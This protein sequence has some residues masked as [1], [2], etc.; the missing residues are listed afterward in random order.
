MSGLTRYAWVVLAYNVAVIL[1]GAF[2]RATGSG[3]GCGSHWPLCNGEVVPRAASAQ[4]LIEFTHRATSGLAVLMVVALLVWVYRA[5]PTGHPARRA[6][7][8]SFIFILGE[9]GVGA[10]LVLLHLVGQNQSAGRA[11]VMALHLVNTFLLLGALTLTACWTAGQ[12]GPRPRQ[13]AGFRPLFRRATAGLLLVGASGAIAA[14]GDT[15]FPSSSLTAALGDDLSASAHFLL[16]LRVLHPVFGVGAGVLV[17][18][19]SYRIVHA[20]QPEA[21]ARATWT[22]VLTVLQLIAGIVNVGL[23]APVLMQM[24]HLLLADLVLIAFVTLWACV[25]NPSSP[26]SSAGH[27]ADDRDPPTVPSVGLVG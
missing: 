2:V 23:L 26:R 4:T 21:A 12:G 24:V 3:A 20:G 6:A 16:R 5:R 17:L 10:L 14:L 9:A 22:A 15:L 11:V 18:V 13:D 1:W 27:L 25:A 8:W 19:L 7:F